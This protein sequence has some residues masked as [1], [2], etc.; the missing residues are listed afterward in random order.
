[1]TVDLRT[2]KAGDKL[3]SCNGMILTYVSPTPEGH[4]YDHF[5]Q[6]PNGSQGARIHDGHVMRNESKRLPS[7]EDIVEIFP[8]A[9]LTVF[10]EV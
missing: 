9:S 5:V 7:D 8:C 2:C 1:M 4:Y 10:D 3:V 6:Y